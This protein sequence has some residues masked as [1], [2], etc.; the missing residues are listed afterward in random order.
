MT[1]PTAHLDLKR[2][3]TRTGLQLGSGLNNRSDCDFF[4][5]RSAYVNCAIIYT[6]SI[7]NKL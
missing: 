7:G 5:S 3:L 4:T 2:A 6:H 1:K